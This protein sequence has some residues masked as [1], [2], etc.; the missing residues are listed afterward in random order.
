M[1]W[2]LGGK[3]GDF[4]LGPGARFAWQHDARQHPDGKISLFDD[5]ALPNE[6]KRSRGL[7]LSVD[8]SA[9]TAQVHR[10]YVHPGSTLLTGSQGNT[11]VLPNAIVLVGWGA[12]PYYTE[13]HQDGS[14][15][16]DGTLRQGQSYRALRF[17]WV[18]TPVDVPAVATHRAGDGVTVYASWNGATEIRSWQVAAGATPSTLIPGRTVARRGFE[19]A[20]PA[21]GSARYVAIRA[22]G[23]D[24]AVLGTSRTVP[25]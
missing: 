9:M 3:K 14:L 8:E 20:I 23:T 22:L 7:V 6:A 19:T 10:E 15:A 21:P 5:E 2:R 11:Q 4:T 16:L 13:F 25:V 18:G 17:P 24:G 1:R 12:L